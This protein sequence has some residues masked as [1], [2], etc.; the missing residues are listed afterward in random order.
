VLHRLSIIDV[1]QRVGL[2]LDENA[3]LTRPD[4]RR[5]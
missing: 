2:T 5:R 3:P 4:N 1:S